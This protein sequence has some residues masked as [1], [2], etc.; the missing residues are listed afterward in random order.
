MQQIY[1]Y[2]APFTLRVVHVSLHVQEDMTPHFFFPR[3]ILVLAHG[4]PLEVSRAAYSHY[5]SY[6]EKVMP[7]SVKIGMNAR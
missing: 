1:A 5:S 6:T 4:W 7:H 2:P 3:C